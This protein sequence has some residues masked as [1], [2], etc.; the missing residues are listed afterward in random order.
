MRARSPSV[1]ARAFER[2]DGRDDATSSGTIEF[3]LFECKRITRGNAAMQRARASASSA[4]VD[5]YVAYLGGAVWTMD[6]LARAKTAD[7][8]EG[9]G[10]GWLAAAA[11]GAGHHAHAVRDV[12]ACRETGMVQV[13]RVETGGG[14]NGTVMVKGLTHAGGCALDVKWSPTMEFLG[15]RAT[16][17]A[18][19][20]LA[21]SSG[22]GEVKVCVVEVT[23]G[24]ENGVVEEAKAEFVGVVPKEYGAPWRLDWNAVVPGRL[25]AGCTSG[26]VVVWDIDEKSLG[27]APTY[28]KFVVAAAAQAGPCRAVRWPPREFAEDESVCA[29]IIACGNDYAVKPQ[30]F[31][32]RAPFAPI[33]DAYERGQPWTLDMAWLPRGTLVV[34]F[35][36]SDRSSGKK[37]GATKMLV[38][39]FDLTA[40][41][42]DD[43]ARPSTQHAVPGRGSP[44]SVDARASSDP[45]S[46]AAMVACA[47]SNGVICVSPMRYVSRTIKSRPDVFDTC[48]GML[49]YDAATNRVADANPVTPPE[50]FDFITSSEQVS[51]KGGTDLFPADRAAMPGTR[52]TPT[53]A[54]H[55]VRWSKDESGGWWL[56]SAGEAGFLRLQRFDGKWVED[57]IAKL[58]RAH[59]GD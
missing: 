51:L 34:G 13:W 44:W 59:R 31:D 26:R 40:N 55:C 27:G 25:A 39:Q 20:A 17:D 50:C 33:G 3:A 18:V 2:S 53:T 1:A 4:V 23:K 46:A 15:D 49:A 32:L 36:T 21:V 10:G 43:G 35:E 9:E 52:E 5:D 42:S 16:D 41:A 30:L 37:K 45:T 6:W 8:R 28:P 7:A 56:A 47:S 48:A 54:Q 12:G 58:E 29:N 38:Q 22:D 57:K 11:R 24:G 14:A 19:G